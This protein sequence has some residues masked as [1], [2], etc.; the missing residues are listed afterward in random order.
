MSWSDR[1]KTRQATAQD[2][3]LTLRLKRLAAIS[4]AM[5]RAD[6]AVEGGRE[7]WEKVIALGASEDELVDEM[8]EASRRV[9]NTDSTVSSGLLNLHLASLYAVAEVWHK[10]GFS[11]P[12]VDELLK[13]PHLVALEGHRHAIFHVDHI[14][15]KAVVLLSQNQEIIEWGKRLAAALRKA[16]R[17]EWAKYP[18]FPKGRQP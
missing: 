14:D 6:A 11:D 7:A 15:A 1:K 12:E 2:E 4:V 13:S 18:P 3:A 16:L 5:L 17:V 9:K 10:W 8:S